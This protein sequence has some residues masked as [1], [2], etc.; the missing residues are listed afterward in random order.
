MNLIS[1]YPK[2]I[3]KVWMLKKSLIILS[4]TKTVQTLKSNILIN[5]IKF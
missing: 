2:D 3:W 4:T 1:F 5:I